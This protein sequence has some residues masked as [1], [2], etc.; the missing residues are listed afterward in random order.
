[1][2]TIQLLE[3]NDVI[4]ADDLVRQ[5]SLMYSGQSD[6]L[7]TISTYGGGPV[8]RLGWIPAKYTC[9]FWVGK[10]VG[11][12]TQRMGRFG[13]DYEFVRGK[14][15]NTHLEKLTKS[16]LKIAQSTWKHFGVES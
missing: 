4:Q 16:Q 7:E 1:M 10:T 8:N 2:I 12:F 13:S 6:Y 11:E 14:V 9:P 3:D 15:P 5:L